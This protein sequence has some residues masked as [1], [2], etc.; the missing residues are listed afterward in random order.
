MKNKQ[1]NGSDKQKF[2]LKTEKS[3]ACV[4][5]VDKSI[6]HISI[7]V[8]WNNWHIPQ[9]SSFLHSVTLVILKI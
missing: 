7:E 8:F 4:L 9:Y 2:W 5:V 1:K 6:K 3:H